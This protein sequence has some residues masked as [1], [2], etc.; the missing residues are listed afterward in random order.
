MARIE[1]KGKPTRKTT[2]A[3]GDIYKDINT[4][5]QYICTFSYRSGS[6]GDF[7]CEWKPYNEAG[8]ADIY[9]M[10]ENKT[11]NMDKDIEKIQETIEPQS[12]T[13]RKDYSSYSKKNR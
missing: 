5:A 8:L 13:K 12:V 10:E 1:G 3:L 11:V 7:D 4:G 9:P 6:E 2:G